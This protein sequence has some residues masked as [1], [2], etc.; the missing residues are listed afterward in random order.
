MHGMPMRAVAQTCP[1][2]PIRM[3]VGFTAGGPADT[4]ARVVAKRPGQ[5]NISVI[6]L[7]GLVDL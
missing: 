4:M 6:S 1:V 2:K 7:G 3:T 5:L